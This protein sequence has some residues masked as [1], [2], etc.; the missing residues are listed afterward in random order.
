MAHDKQSKK[1]EVNQYQKRML[2][3]KIT[4]SKHIIAANPKTAF[5]VFEL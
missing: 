3:A 5:V 4:T 1:P 2:D